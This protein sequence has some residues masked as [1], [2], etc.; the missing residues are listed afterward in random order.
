V[1]DTPQSPLLSLHDVQLAFGGLRAVDGIS[2]DVAEGSITALIGPNGAGK[3]TLF[4]IVAGFHSP[5]SGRVVFDGKDVTRRAAHS[6]ARLGLVR[7]FQLPR[8]FAR[9]SVLDNML[10]AAPD[11]PADGLLWAMVPGRGRARAAEI[12]TRAHE[13]LA[14]FGL[15]KKSADYAGALSGGQRKLLEFSRALMAKPRLLL[16]DE[17][18]AGV[19]PALGDELL[20][21]MERLRAEEG[22][23]FLFVEHDMTAV[24]EHADQVVCMGEGRLVAQGPPEIVRAHPAVLEAYLGAEDVEVEA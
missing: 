7:T 1:T 5:D 18:L 20:A 11:Q 6:R 3:S 16:L 22:L 2:F 12:E 13:L 9:M 24:M 19:N 4:G 10:L 15:G 21:H 14:G 8:V 17:P 23:T